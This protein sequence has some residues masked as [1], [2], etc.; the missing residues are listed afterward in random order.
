VTI[1]SPGGGAKLGYPVFVVRDPPATMTFGAVCRAGIVLLKLDDAGIESRPVSEG[2]APAKS[3]E[4]R[5]GFHLYLLIGQ[6]NMAGR[7]RIAT[8]DLSINPR[9]LTLDERNRWVVALDPI[10][11]DKPIAGV[12]L[13]TT[14][15]KAMATRHPDAVIGLIPCAVG[16]SSMMQRRKGAPPTGHWGHLYDNAVD[17]ARIALRDGVLKGILW[18]QGE[19]DVAPAKVAGYRASLTALVTALRRDLAAGDVPFV[20]GELGVWDAEKHAARRAFN[21]NLRGLPGWFGRGAAVRA[22]GL[23]HN[24]DGT[25]FSSEALRELGHRYAEAMAG[26]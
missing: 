24:G 13:G 20:A 21:E 5:S 19:A 6:S 25:H 26:F 16:G 3:A 10:H 22:D 7:G 9:V 11:F 12:G 2:M 15:G 8:E 14:F 1:Q 18:H 23:G 4:E 17:R